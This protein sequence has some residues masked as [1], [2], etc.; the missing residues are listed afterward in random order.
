M[1]GAR[2][3]RRAALATHPLGERVGIDGAA[4]QRRRR[5]AALPRAGAP[6]SREA[7]MT[8]VSSIRSMPRSARNSSS[9]VGS[10]NG[11]IR[12]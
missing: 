1:G 4:V 10:E 8:R 3:G 11:V 12:K 5:L 7:T 9:P 6:A 2:L